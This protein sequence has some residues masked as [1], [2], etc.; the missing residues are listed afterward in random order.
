MRG[1]V[2]WR[3]LEYESVPFKNRESSSLVHNMII[4][5]GRIPE[6]VSNGSF[7]L[8]INEKQHFQHDI[9]KRDAS[10]QESRL[11]AE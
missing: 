9:W 10:G 7:P 2:Y 8:K 3:N 6:H 5:N 4:Q 11:V 1:L